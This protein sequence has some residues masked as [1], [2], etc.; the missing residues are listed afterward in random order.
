MAEFAES[1]GDTGDGPRQTHF[2]MPEM[3]S[4][5]AALRMYPPRFIEI[6]VHELGADRVLS[7]AGR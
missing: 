6:K 7:R 4:S 3:A 5:N 2:A 1:S